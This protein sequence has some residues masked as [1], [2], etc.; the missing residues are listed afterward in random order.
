[1]GKDRRESQQVSSFE[2][3]TVHTVCAS[4]T[5]TAVDFRI[6]PK[7]P[8]FMMMMMMTTSCFFW[9]IYLCRPSVSCFPL[10]FHLEAVS[11]S[12]ARCS[13]RGL[14][15]LSGVLTLSVRTM[16]VGRWRLSITINC[17]LSILNSSIWDFRSVFT[18]SKR[19]DS[20]RED[21]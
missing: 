15:S 2:V 18:T 1:M 10:W 13:S 20:Y 17:C 9:Q 14:A 5:K 21:R 7:W 12:A 19:S 16:Q 11:F 3:K 6:F 8:P 4:T